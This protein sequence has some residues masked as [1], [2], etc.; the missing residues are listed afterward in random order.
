MYSVNWFTRVPG[1]SSALSLFLLNLNCS[2][3][4]EL[5]FWG[6]EIPLQLQKSQEVQVPSWQDCNALEQQSAFRW[7]K[8]AGSPTGPCQ[9]LSQGHKEG[10]RSMDCTGTDEQLVGKHTSSSKELFPLI[11]PLTKIHPKLLWWLQLWLQ[12]TRRKKKIHF[13]F[14]HSEF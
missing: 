10:H 3:E 4:L 5:Q 13:S 12:G 11:S 8:A 1:V 7:Q 9:C 14:I 6:L 2:K